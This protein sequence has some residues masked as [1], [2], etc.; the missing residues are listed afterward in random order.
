MLQERLF[1]SI[2][3]IS[4]LREFLFDHRGNDMD[5]FYKSLSTSEHSLLIDILDV[6]SIW[7][8]YDISPWIFECIRRLYLY[9]T[10]SDPKDIFVS[11]TDTLI[12]CQFEN[13]RF[14]VQT[15]YTTEHIDLS[16]YLYN[17]ESSSVQVRISRKCNGALLSGLY[18]YKEREAWEL[19]GILSV[20]R[21]LLRMVDWICI[22]M[23]VDVIELIDCSKLEFQNRKVQVKLPI[24]ML[25]STGTT[26]YEGSG[27]IPLNTT[28]LKLVHDQLEQDRRKTMYHMFGKESKKLL[29]C[30]NI[31]CGSADLLV[32]DYGNL[33]LHKLFGN[34]SF[35]I[36]HI[37]DIMEILTSTFQYCMLFRSSYLKIYGDRE[38]TKRKDLRR[39]RPYHHFRFLGY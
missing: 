20:G 17:I 10:H 4:A 23:G 26:Y 11:S 22:A 24:L 3:T 25:L 34:D 15:F 18:P 35:I 14:F 2:Q 37:Q 16:I 5:I 21:F 1:R 38:Y 6:H 29:Y 8:L 32:K 7:Q 36:E 30:A 27:Y 12:C 31:D 33:V 28:K 19:F 39:I 13:V 9:P